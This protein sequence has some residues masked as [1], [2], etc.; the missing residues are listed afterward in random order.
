MHC[1]DESSMWRRKRQQPLELVSK[2]KPQIQ[3]KLSAVFSHE[4]NNRSWHQNSCS[5]QWRNNHS[6]IY[7]EVIFI[8]SPWFCESRFDSSLTSPMTL[9]EP[10]WC[11]LFPPVTQY[12][13]CMVVYIPAGVGQFAQLCPH[14]GEYMFVLSVIFRWSTEML[15]L[16][17]MWWEC[18]WA[19]VFV[20]Q[21]HCVS[22]TRMF[23]CVT[24]KMADE[25]LCSCDDFHH[26]A[27]CVD[28]AARRASVKQTNLSPGG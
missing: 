10:R 4:N 13:T 21:A 26:D 19:T 16:W 8:I 11:F 7:L 14:Q 22:M 28:A 17:S 2:I 3:L 1:D 25:L 15:L 24:G 9:Q 18:D 5:I 27:V 12:L 6:V 20:K 23:C